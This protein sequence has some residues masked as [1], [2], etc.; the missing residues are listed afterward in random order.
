M[1]PG[2]LI[3]SS[4]LDYE[5]KKKHTFTVKATIVRIFEAYATVVIN[6]LNVN[7]ECPRLPS[8]MTIKYRGNPDIGDVIGKVTAIDVDST[9]RYTISANSDLTV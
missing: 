9:S 8:T 2:Q 5:T 6:V 3:L 4:A 7:D 1:F